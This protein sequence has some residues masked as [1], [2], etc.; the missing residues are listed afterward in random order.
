MHHHTQLIFVFLV[1]TGFFHV[2]QFG[3]FGERVSLCQPG[4][5]AVT[6]SPLTATSASW[7]Q[8]VPPVSVSRVAGFIGACLHAR[9][10][11]VI[12]VETGFDP[13]GQAVSNF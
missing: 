4:W 3:Y 2:G 11:F 7:I 12:L 5:S 13:I 10:I 1:E 9:Q 8:A 6:Q